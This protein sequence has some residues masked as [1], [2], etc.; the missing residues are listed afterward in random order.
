M[1][2]LLGTLYKAGIDAYR[3]VP[4]CFSG[5]KVRGVDIEELIDSKVKAPSGGG[6]VPELR[7]IDL[8]NSGTVV[9][10]ND[11][12]DRHLLVMGAMLVTQHAS[13]KATLTLEGVGVL[14][15]SGMPEVEDL[16]LRCLLA[17]GESI[18]GS[19]KGK[20]TGHLIVQV[21]RL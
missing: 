9:L 11:D 1:A 15:L 6:T 7:V 3:G 21:V 14:E 10:Q 18:A 5:L 20:V 13:E 12:L 2:S 16:K 8:N 17:P 19:V 4:N